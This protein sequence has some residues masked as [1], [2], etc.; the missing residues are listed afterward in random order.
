MTT[1]RHLERLW[2]GRAWGKLLHELL[3]NRPEY[4]QHLQT[5]LHSLVAC[6]AQAMIRLDELNQTHTALFTRLLR[7]VIA[8]Q[9]A[10]GGWRDP[11]TTA[12]CLRALLIDGGH[13]LSVDRGMSYL[14]TMQKDEGIWPRVPIR[15]MSPDAFT[16][17]FVLFQLASSGQF[18][19]VVRFRDAIRW[20]QTHE[21]SLD[22]TT[23]RLWQFTAVTCE[24]HSRP[25][26]L[27][28]LWS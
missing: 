15:R 23:R 18:R 12:L 7:T 22:E 11:L 19:R 3:V 28:P 10:D 14:A 17:A 9:D 24:R 6:A 5:E 13:G 8:S 2:S 25:C 26:E 4:S 27:A 1:V 16:S 20:F 21:D